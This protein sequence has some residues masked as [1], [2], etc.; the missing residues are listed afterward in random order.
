MEFATVCEM[1]RIRLEVFQQGRM[2]LKVQAPGMEDEPLALIVPETIGEAVGVPA[3]KEIAPSWSEND[4]GEL[5]YRW[6][7]E[8]KVEFSARVTPGNDW[9]DVA[10]EIT[11]LSEQ[12]YRNLFV[13]TCLNPGHGPGDAPSF[14]EPVVK[15]PFIRVEGEFKSI[16]ELPPHDGPRPDTHFIMSSEAGLGALPE[17]NESFRNHHSVTADCGFIASEGANG[18]SIAMACRDPLFLFHNRRCW[19]IHACPNIP[20][21]RPGE[22]KNALQRIYISPQGKQELYDRAR[23]EL[24]IG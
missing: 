8:G 5:S 9:A 14:R 12:A 2:L 10:L 7:T 6:R 11:N 1:E 22:R 3:E 17:S 19:C 23:R 4:R 15:G 21:L 24:N 20:E 16:Y 13:F 18:Y